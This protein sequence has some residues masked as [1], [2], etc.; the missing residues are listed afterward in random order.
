MTIEIESVKTTSMEMRGTVVLGKRRENKVKKEKEWFCYEMLLFMQIIIERI[1]NN[2]EGYSI[3]SYL[4]T[5]LSL[6]T[7]FKKVDQH[8]GGK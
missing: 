2:G 8:T 5:Q 3:M 7:Y 4:Q 1:E 6:K